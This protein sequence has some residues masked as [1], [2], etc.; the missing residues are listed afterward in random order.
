MEKTAI[1]LGATGLVGS[2]L[3]HTLLTTDHF[4]KVIH[5]GRSPVGVQHHK[6]TEHIVDLFRKE[7]WQNK[8]KADTVFCCIG[9]TSRKTPD[10]TTYEKTDKGIPVSV[11]DVCVQNNIAQLFVIS[12]MGA[13][14]NSVF[15]YPRIKGEM[16]EE[17]LQ[18]DIPEIYLLQPSIIG[19]KREETRV[20]ESLGKFVMAV[21]DPLLRGPLT[22][23]KMV[24]PKQIT[25]AMLYLAEHPFLQ[26]RISSDKILQLSEQY[27][28]IY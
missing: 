19:G 18:R 6:L 12:S 13:D 20:A 15:E 4:Q 10:Y 5:F 27:K 1:I 26:N 16:E 21:I 23:Y 28:S 11:A 24:H 8:F 9:T 3:L 17:V 22:K 25:L 2:H 7:Q 14:A